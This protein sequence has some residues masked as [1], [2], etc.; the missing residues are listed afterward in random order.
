MNDN[1][2]DYNNTIELYKRFREVLR[3]CNSIIDAFYF[4]DKYI[5]K[6]PNN[7]ELIN[8][9]IQGRQYNDILDMRTIKNTLEEL[10]KC[11]YRDDVDEMINKIAKNGRLDTVQ[12]RSLLRIS[13][14]KPVRITKISKEKMAEIKKDERVDITKKCP[15][16]GSECTTKSD[17]DY[18]ICGYHDSRIGFDWSGCGKDWCFQ[19]EKILCK[20][21][22]V[23]QLFNDINRIHDDECCRK[24]A[25]SH[26]KNYDDYCQ[27]INMNVR[28]INGTITIGNGALVITL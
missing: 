23:N 1:D 18:I 19:C 26:G 7:K 2:N 10:N 25:E 21:W 20:S 11:Q 5:K 9:M 16:C 22:D 17:T 28:R 15:H 12:T 8:S 14:M 27:C 13:R 4:A 24:H 3:G 6:Y